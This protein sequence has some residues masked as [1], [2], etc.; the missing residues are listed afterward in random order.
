MS[1]ILEQ[2]ELDRTFFYQLAIFAGLFLILGPLYFRPFLRLFEARH[3]R[4]VEDREAAERLMAQ[5]QA[6]LD[7]YK[8]RL[9]EERFAAKKDYDALMAEARKE[10]TLILS[11]AREEAKKITQEAAESVN[12]QREQLKK[13][14]EADVESI[15]QSVSE[16]LLSRKF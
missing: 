1:A 4:T 2:L 7:E 5:A 16:K 6:K 8:R 12:Q 13:Q 10:E 14:L 15:A 3:K 11:D 9:A